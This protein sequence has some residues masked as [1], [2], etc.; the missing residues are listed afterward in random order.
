MSLLASLGRFLVANIVAQKLPALRLPHLLIHASQ[1]AID[2]VESFD[3]RQLVLKA[4]EAEV[5]ARRDERVDLRCREVLEERRDVV[6]NA[7]P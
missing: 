3:W 5:S 1:V 7:V 4:G 2:D 6:V